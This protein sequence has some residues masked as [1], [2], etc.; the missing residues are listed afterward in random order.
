MITSNFAILSSMKVAANVGMAT[1]STTTD[2]VQ[3]A[4]QRFRDTVD[5]LIQPG[6]F[7][8]AMSVALIFIIISVL[9]KGTEKVINIA[10]EAN[11]MSDYV[12]F[13]LTAMRVEMD[14]MTFLSN[15][16]EMIKQFWNGVT[17]A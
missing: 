16:G 11:A 9:L 17:G 7:Q 10:V 4:G 3:D 5:F 15:I 6:N 13:A 14:V 2:I 8:L 12:Y 1:S